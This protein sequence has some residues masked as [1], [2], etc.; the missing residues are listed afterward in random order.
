MRAWTWVAV[1]GMS[2]LALQ[3]VAAGENWRKTARQEERGTVVASAYPEEGGC[4]DTNWRPGQ[5]IGGPTNGVTSH[6]FELQGGTAG[7]NYVLEA[8]SG[9]EAVDVDITFVDESDVVSP[10]PV[11]EGARRT[12]RGEWGK[13]PRGAQVAYVCLYEGTR[14]TFTYVAGAGVKLPKKA[15]SSR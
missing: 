3:P 7:R 4:G 13:V 10:Q 2:A 15:R 14:A 11:S 8:A 9:D 5:I 12:T 6:R 1:L